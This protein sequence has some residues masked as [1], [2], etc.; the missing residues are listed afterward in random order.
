MPE[1]LI[2]YK[3]AKVKRALTDFSKYLDFKII[4]SDKKKSTAVKN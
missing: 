4:T 1:L 2:S 3:N